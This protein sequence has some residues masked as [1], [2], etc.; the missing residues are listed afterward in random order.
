MKEKPIILLCEDILK[1]YNLTLKK[2][3]E[4]E[5]D[6]GYIDKDYLLFGT[7]IYVFSLFEV[8][9]NNSLEY[10]LKSIPGKI[11]TNFKVDKNEILGTNLV[12]N[13]I[14]DRAKEHVIKLSYDSL[15]GYIENYCNIFGIEHLKDQDLI[16][17]IIE[18]KTRR[19]L[20]LHNDLYIKSEDTN[21]TWKDLFNTKPTITK[22]YISS[23]INI[24]KKVL[25]ELKIKLSK[26]YSKYTKL[27]ILKDIWY[28]MFDSS[29]LKFEDYWIIKE[30]K[31]QGFNYE[32]AKK[33]VNTLSS[34]EKTLLAIW[35]QQFNS[36]I[37]GKLFEFKEMRFWYSIEKELTLFI[38]VINRYPHL[39]YG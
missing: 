7:F 3:N 23:T 37:N 16:N 38:E 22:S 1:P 14:H 39:F 10:F 15:D 32:Y 17:E 11:R 27:K 12:Q 24:F 29:V 33:Y 8:T 34:Y 28:Y 9:L 2:Y 19:N 5:E 18:K 6:I 4:I 13:L 21:T 35:I 30:G 20:I 36:D 26:K 25:K 31:I